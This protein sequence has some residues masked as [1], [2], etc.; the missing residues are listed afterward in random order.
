MPEQVEG[1]ARSC[2][3]RS[4]GEMLLAL[5]MNRGA[6]CERNRQM[7]VSKCMVP[8]AWIKRNATAFSLLFP[9]TCYR[10][11]SKR[12][13]PRRHPPTLSWEEEIYQDCESMGLIKC[14]DDLLVPLLEDHGQ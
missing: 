13:P 7:S 1:A 10:Q 12:A 8:H 3:K 6:L 2:S 11:K 14:A 9:A 4:S 5:H